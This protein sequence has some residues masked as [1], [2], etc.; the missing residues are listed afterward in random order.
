M[1]ECG[2]GATRLI[3]GMLGWC[4][5]SLVWFGGV[6]ISLLGRLSGGLVGADGHFCR[7]MYFIL[8]TYHKLLVNTVTCDFYVERNTSEKS[9]F[10]RILFT[11]KLSPVKCCSIECDV[12]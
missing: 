9:F 6:V 3:D 4:L 8:C 1:D 11:K 12:A 5:C 7:F 2:H 10:A